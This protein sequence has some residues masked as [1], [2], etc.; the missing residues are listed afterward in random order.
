MTNRFQ[1]HILVLPE[2]RANSQ[3][4]NGFLLDLHSAALRRIQVLEEVGGWR[5]VLDQ[6]EAEHVAAMERYTE[7]Y[8]I[9]L[10]DFDRDEG[11]M[12]YAKGRI[13]EHLR[14]RVFILGTWIDPETLR[15]NLGSYET[16]GNALAEDCRG[17]TDHTWGHE[18]L[19]HNADE[20]NRLREYIRPI[21]FA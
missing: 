8:M 19:R 1:P 12:E 14:D 15:R 4:A 2:D 6:F 21:L 20:I 13:P 9:L 16:I 11:R 17:E 10:I 7:R 5:V 18:L 3:L